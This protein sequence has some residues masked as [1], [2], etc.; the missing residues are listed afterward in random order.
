MIT[1]FIFGRKKILNS[2][3]EYEIIAIELASDPKKL[4]E[5]KN[6]LKINKLKTVLFNTKLFAKH[7]ESAYI[8]IYEKFINNKKPD[9]IEI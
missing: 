7:I 8:K 6:K 3:T 4:R 1:F 5:I 2:H 9:H